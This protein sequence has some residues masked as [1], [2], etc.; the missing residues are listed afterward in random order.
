MAETL[1]FFCAPP[2]NNLFLAHRSASLRADISRVHHS[3]HP[4]PCRERIGQEQGAPRAGG[5]L[6]ARRRQPQFRVGRMEG[7]LAL[8]E[9]V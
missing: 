8:P 6:G 2:Q 1:F 5:H 4:R 9:R 7:G 3:T